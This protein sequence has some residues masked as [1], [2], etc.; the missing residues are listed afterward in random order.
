[1]KKHLFFVA[2]AGVALASCVKND[3]EVPETKNVKIGFASPVLYQ[4]VDTKV[5]VFGEIGSHKYDGSETIY[6]YPRD[7]EF[8]IFAVEHVGDL[9]SWNSATAT[10][11]NGQAISYNTSLDAWVPLKDDDSFYYWPD[12]EKMSF[13]AMSPAE[14]DVV[15]AGV[16]YS[17]T[18]L[19]IT[20]FAIADNP[21][22]QYDLLYSER[23]VN[24]TASDMVDGADYYSGIPISFKHAL[25]SIHF[26]LKTDVTEK[27]TLTS[28][29]LKNAQNMG[30]FNENYNETNLT[31]SPEW[32]ID[33]ASQATSYTSFTGSVEFPLNP[34]YVSALAANDGTDDGDES[35]PLLMLPQTLGD[36]VVVEV[37]YTV[38]GEPKIRT[39][40]LNQYPA[41]DPI[42]E[43]E[44][45]TKYTYRLFYSKNAQIQDIIYFSPGTEGWAEGGVI[46]VIL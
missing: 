1:M 5:N 44:V 33:D 21:A 12:N 26:S 22:K 38:G 36:N 46:E 7:E 8:K 4:N 28:I 30:N 45:G 18:G 17:S 23:S 29:T 2:L 35:H 6:T 16:A 43:W 39:V 13:A 11:F 34:Q 10:A 9:V 42:T 14:L 25:S 40:Q 19:S 24:Q 27:V 32:T 15:G 3:V 37:A 31:R 41:D 20:D